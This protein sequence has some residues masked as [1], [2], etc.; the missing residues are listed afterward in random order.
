MNPV[1]DLTLPFTLTPATAHEIVLSEVMWDFNTAGGLVGQLI[2]TN[3][4]DG[5]NMSGPEP[6]DENNGW[7]HVITTSTTPVGFTWTT[8][9][10]GIQVGSWSA[11]AVAFKGAP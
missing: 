9:F 6:V 3:I 1:G 11:V 7:G 5:M 4:F 10:S 2:D 8:V